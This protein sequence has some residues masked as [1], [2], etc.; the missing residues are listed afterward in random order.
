MN[1][2]TRE[3]MIGLVLL[4]LLLFGLCGSAEAGKHGLFGDRMKNVYVVSKRTARAHNKKFGKYSGYTTYRKV[5]EVTGVVIKEVRD[6]S[7]RVVSRSR[8]QLDS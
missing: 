3:I 4:S 8:F 1:R 2:V 6:K 7:G 5:D